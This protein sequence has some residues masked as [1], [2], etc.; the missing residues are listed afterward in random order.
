MRKVELSAVTTASSEYS[1]RT[2]QTDLNFRYLPKYFFPE[3]AQSN[4]TQ[5]G[6]CA[7]AAHMFSLFFC[8]CNLHL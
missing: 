3:A 7:W 6:L 1:D 8:K 5:V 4:E 2:A